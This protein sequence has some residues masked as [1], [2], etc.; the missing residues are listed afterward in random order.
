MALSNTDLAN[1]IIKKLDNAGFSSNQYSLKV[2]QAIA[3]AI[4][5]HITKN[6]VVK[7]TDTHGDTGSGTIT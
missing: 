7:T 6:A 4:V 2:W 1:L 5:E 3:E